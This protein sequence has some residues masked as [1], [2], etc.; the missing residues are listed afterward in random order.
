MGKTL[1]PKRF[2]WELAGIVR[3]IWE[4]LCVFVL[5]LLNLPSIEREKIIKFR[6]KVIS[7]GKD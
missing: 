7:I 3:Y 1:A 6:K 2:L 5:P 4:I